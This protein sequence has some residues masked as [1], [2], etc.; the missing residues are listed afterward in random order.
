MKY[1]GRIVSLINA[2]IV[3]LGFILHY[4]TVHGNVEWFHIVA[5]VIYLG[6]GWQLG[7]KYDK[8]KYLSEKDILTQSY[9]RR[10]VMDSFPKLQS[11]SDRKGQKLIVFLIDIDD[12]KL[13]NDRYNHAMGDRFLQLIS[14]T[15]KHTFRESDY[16]VRWGGDEFL[17]L[18]PCT[19][20]TG[21]KELQ[22]R[23]DKELSK[24]SSTV[25]I[26]VSVSVGYAVYPDEGR[27]LDELIKIADGKMYSNKRSKR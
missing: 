4:Y 5:L 17:V 1:T 13:I 10:F 6:L 3:S 19:D 25:L 14:D 20:V 9:N 21:I 27:S 26:D 2:M 18:I 24:L 8:V 12:F 7:N 23:L 11:L 15:L 22:Q 16:V